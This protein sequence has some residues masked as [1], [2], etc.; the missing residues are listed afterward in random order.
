M[1]HTRGLTRSFR[2]KGETVEAVRGLD[3]DIEAGSVVAFLGPNGAGK[4]TTLRMLTTLLPPTSGTAVVAGHDVLTDPSGVRNR[5]GCLGQG[6]SA[7]SNFRASDELIA[8]GRAY[9]LS[10]A[11]ARARAE[12]LLTALELDGLAK[13]TVGTLSGGQR[14]RLDIAMALVHEPELLFLDEPTTGL[15][16]H[17]RAHIWEHVLRLHKEFGATIVFTTHYLEEAD[18]RARRVMVVDHGR[19]IADDPPEKLKADLAGDRITLGTADRA[20]TER[21]AELAR[22][23][24]TVHEVTAEDTEVRVRTLHGDTQL[25]ALLRNLEAVGVRVRTARLSRPTLDDV[26]L[27]LTGRTLRESADAPTTTRGGA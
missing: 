16:P 21:A 10:R 1:I 24:P 14:R 22:A 15:D 20:D 23:L 27:S 9:G 6:N 26:F 7:G 8:Q 25:P 2:V 5:I 17:S 18:L 19:V 13:R 3:L 4:S 12:R 11:K